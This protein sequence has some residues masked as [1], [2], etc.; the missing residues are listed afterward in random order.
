MWSTYSIC[1]TNQILQSCWVPSRRKAAIVIPY[2]PACSPTNIGSPLN[3]GK[4]PIIGTA[5]IWGRM[6]R[7]TDRHGDLEMC[8]FE[9]SHTESGTN[10]CNSCESSSHTGIHNIISVNTEISK[11]K[12]Q[13]AVKKQNLITVH[14]LTAHPVHI[15]PLQFRHKKK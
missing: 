13:H 15:I 10:Y 2:I 12:L 5:V 8:P 1:S 14:T 3:L 7:Q 11:S 4:G 9:T 6:D